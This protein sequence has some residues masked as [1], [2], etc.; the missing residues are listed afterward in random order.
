MG[1][2]HREQFSPEEAPEIVFLEFSTEP[3]CPRPIP[4]RDRRHSVAAT[5]IDNLKDPSQLARP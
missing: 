2:A 4:L 3:G 5:K 1:A